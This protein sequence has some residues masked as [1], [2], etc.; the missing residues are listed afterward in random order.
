MKT[1]PT[2]SKQYSDLYR[3]YM[4]FISQMLPREKDEL[5]M[6][7]LMKR[8]VDGLNKRPWHGSEHLMFERFI[9]KTVEG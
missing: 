6:A 2:P 1:A 3:A 7:L 5:M 4:V 9:E 8:S